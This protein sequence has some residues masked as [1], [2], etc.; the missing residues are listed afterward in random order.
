MRNVREGMG[1]GA[2][3]I[4]GQILKKLVIKYLKYFVPYLPWAKF[5]N[6]HIISLSLSLYL[7]DL[8]FNSEVVNLISS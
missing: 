8:C 7:Q 4:S 5:V 6:I 2:E 3:F 1:R